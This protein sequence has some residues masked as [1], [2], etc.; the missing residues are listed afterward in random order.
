MGIELG[1]D[2]K[3]LSDLR[4]QVLVLDAR[5]SGNPAK[6]KVGEISDTSVYD[7]L[8]FVSFG[9]SNST[10][11]PT[12]SVRDSFELAKQELKEIRDT[13]ETLTTKSIPEFE[14]SLQSKGAPWIRGQSLP[15]LP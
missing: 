14:R 11:G 1:D 2:D 6:N 7:R 12:K 10:Y 4:N 15:E 3:K 8:F 13:F 5:L 9:V